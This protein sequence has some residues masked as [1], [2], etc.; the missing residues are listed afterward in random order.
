MKTKMH[1]RQ[2]VF[3]FILILSG[4]GIYLNAI[5][6][7]F[8]FDDNVSIVNEKNIRMSAFSFESLKT[9]ATQTFYTKNHFRPVV[10]ISF[11]LNYYF[12]GY[13]P[14]MYHIV[15]ILIHIMAGI[16]LYFF[17]QITL[18]LSFNLSRPAN[19]SIATSDMKNLDYIAFFSALIWMVNPVNV[20]AVTY[21]TQRM[22]SM[23]SLFFLLS[24]LFYARGRL[25]MIISHNGLERNVNKYVFFFCVD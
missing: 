1:F 12:D 19:S 15:N 21:V 2:L 3:I 25:S 13:H 6:C 4:V 7:P 16:S 5:H 9:A 8:V 20:Q 11:A 18:R 14:R 10:M 17:I 23:M 22:T 24:I